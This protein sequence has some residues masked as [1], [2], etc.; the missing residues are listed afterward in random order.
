M[1]SGTANLLGPEGS[2][3]VSRVSRVGQGGIRDFY[4]L[5]VGMGLGSIYGL[6]SRARR[7]FS[8]WARLQKNTVR[9]CLAMCCQVMQ[10]QARHQR[11]RQTESTPSRRLS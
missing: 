7:F 1:E 9:P 2:D 10:A 5:W 6:F 11:D 8:S 3:I 4:K